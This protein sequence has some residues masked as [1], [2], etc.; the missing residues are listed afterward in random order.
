MVPFLNL[1]VAD[2]MTTDVVTVTP[3]TPL[4]ELSG[5]L[6]T[7]RF[8]AIPVMDGDVLAGLVTGFDFLRAFLFTPD[9]II[10]HYDAILARP[11][12][13][14]MAPAPECVEPG[15]PLS[16]VLNR[17]IETRNKSF[18]VTREGRLV[19]II[20]REDIFKGL[21]REMGRD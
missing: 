3:Q 17:M 19:G 10:P 11:V 6:E 7:Y 20:A 13:D 15:Q 2:V 16:R 5:L 4:S 18:P 8:N 14:V 12:A 1:Q 21:R 9:S